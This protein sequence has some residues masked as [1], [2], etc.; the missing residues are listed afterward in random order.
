M[1]LLVTVVTAT[2]SCFRYAG[3]MKYISL[4]GLADRRMEFPTNLPY[5]QFLYD[6]SDDSSLDYQILV[7][8]LTVFGRHPKHNFILYI[9]VIIL[10]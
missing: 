10:P 1:Q 4:Y 3:S 7:E 9:S 8:V 6:F 2:F 5:F